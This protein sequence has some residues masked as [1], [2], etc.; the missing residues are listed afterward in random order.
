MPSTSEPRRAIQSDGIRQ[1]AALI[2]LITICLI[3]GY[4]GSMATTP[5]IPTWYAGL[6]KPFFTPPNSV[7]PIVWTLLYLMMAVAAWLIWRQNQMLRERRLGLA[8]FF[9]QLILNV[10]WSWAFFGA[11]SPGAGLIAILLLLA[12]IIW[13]IAAFWPVSR[14][15][16]WMM[17]PYLCWVAFASLLNGAIYLMN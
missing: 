2:I 1:A 11:H 6:N 16:A 13:T 12:A 15:A 3:A 5:N 9:T 7:F 10:I 4:L 8:A 14:A 17:V